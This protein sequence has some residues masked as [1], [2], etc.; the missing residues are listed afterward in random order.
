MKSSII[1]CQPRTKELCKTR[2]FPN[3]TADTYLPSPVLDY[4]CS[5]YSIT[6]CVPFR[7]SCILWCLE[8]ADWTI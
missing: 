2:S 7:Y 3:E 8:I 5:L 4:D 1:S 6:A